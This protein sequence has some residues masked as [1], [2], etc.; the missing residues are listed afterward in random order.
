M[1]RR[2]MTKPRRFILFDFKP[3]NIIVNYL[4]IWDKCS[5][6]DRN[7]KT[8]SGECQIFKGEFKKM[9]GELDNRFIGF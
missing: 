3:E 6:P 9:E 2:N 4:T 8:L 5:R 7:I 1:E